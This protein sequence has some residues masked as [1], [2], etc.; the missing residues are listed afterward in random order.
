MPRRA[1]EAAP[2]T[3]EPAPTTHRVRTTAQN[4]ADARSL[5]ESRKLAHAA[6]R[7]ALANKKGSRAACASGL[8]GDPKVVTRNIVEPLLR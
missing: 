5:C 8:F 2:E 3:P 4:D 7:W 1:A 6:A